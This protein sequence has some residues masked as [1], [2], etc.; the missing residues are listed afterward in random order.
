MRPVIAA[1]VAMTFALTR[2]RLL[3][4]GSVPSIPDLASQP[5]INT[6]ESDVTKEHVNDTEPCSDG[7]SG[8]DHT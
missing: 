6:V 3:Q 8:L 7:S 1:S 4:Q 5:V 2:L